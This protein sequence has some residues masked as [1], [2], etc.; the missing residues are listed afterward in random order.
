MSTQN[1]SVWSLTAAAPNDCFSCAVYKLA[2]L[3]TYLLTYCAV[4]N[5]TGRIS[6][7]AQNVRASAIA[8]CGDESLLVVRGT[9][10]EL[11][12]GQTCVV[13]QFL[14]VDVVSGQLIGTVGQPYRGL[15]PATAEFINTSD[16]VL[17]VSYPVLSEN[18]TGNC[19]RL[20][21]YS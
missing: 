8:L 13:S 14:V 16:N 18:I 1:A 12:D 21:S 20:P 17:L 4:C 11:V 6:F 19:S 5:V 3:L 15:A 9:H 2:Y 7:A 10:T